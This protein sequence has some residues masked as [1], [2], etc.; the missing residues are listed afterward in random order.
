[1]S[2]T[3]KKIYV[4][5]RFKNTYSSSNSDF[6]FTIHQSIDLPDNTFCYIDDVQIPHTWYSIEDYNNKIYFQQDNIG[7]ITNKILVLTIQ[8]HTGTNLATNIQN[9]LN[10]EFGGGS[11]VVTYNSNKGTITIT[12]QDAGRLFQ[13]FTDDEL[14]STPVGWNI[15]YDPSN[16][17]SA[18]DVFRLTSSMG[19]VLSYE[20]GFLDLLNTHSVYIRSPNLGS[21]SSIGARGES[22]IIKKI[23]VS[24]S[25]GFL[26][27]D[28]VVS[29]HDKIDVSRQT[30]KTLEFRLTN[31]RGQVINLHGSHISFSLIFSQ[32]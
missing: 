11:Y 17:S 10:T 19:S 12:S 3:V 2:S 5:T 7:V 16:L 18:N 20:T 26:I 25:Y 6:K 4:D 15:G 27:I 14:Q 22:D 31:V 30:L 9:L 13:M 23:P 24:S 1:M 21:F 29:N 8:N 28:S 32:D